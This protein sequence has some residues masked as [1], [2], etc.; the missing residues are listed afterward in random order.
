MTGVRD[1]VRNCAGLPSEGE[2]DVGIRAVKGGGERG[3][4]DGIDAG[5]AWGRGRRRGRG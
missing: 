3:L 5:A 1:R 2:G 4:F